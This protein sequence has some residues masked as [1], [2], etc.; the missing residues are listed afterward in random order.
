MK[1]TE[2]FLLATSGATV[3]GRNIDEN[4]ITQMAQ[5]YDPATYGA[6]LNIEHIKGFSGDAPFNAYGDVLALSAEEVTVNFNGT[7]EKRMGLYGV[8]SVTDDAEK[9]NESSQKVYPSVEIN[10]NFAGKGYAYLMGC[11][12][13]DTPAAIGTEKMK[14]NRSMPD[15]IK[16]SATDSNITAASLNIETAEETSEAAGAF[17]SIKKF[18]DNMTQ[19]QPLTDDTPAQ[20]NDD[21]SGG[22]ESDPSTNDMNATFAQFGVMMGQMAAAME[23]STKATNASIEKLST[24]MTALK[25]DLED[26]ESGGNSPRP[27]SSGNHFTKTDC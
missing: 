18:F 8:F 24:E 20:T 5:S 9:L 13:T 26:T 21:K 23:A 11:A 15:T 1:T 3:D 19:G 10:P 7:D 27:K 14:F 17:A 4:M 2:K 22:N 12:L 16:L 6:R 25:S